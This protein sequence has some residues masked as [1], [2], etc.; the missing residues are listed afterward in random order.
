M[1]TYDAISKLLKIFKDI[2][3]HRSVI[4][5]PKY[6]PV[7]LLIII[8]G[9]AYLYDYQD[10]LTLR[11]QGPHQWRQCDCLSITSKFYLNESSFFQPE[12]YNLLKDNEGKAASDFP[13]VYYLTQV[14]I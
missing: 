6:S 8:L 2:F 14:A 13:L 7:V 1:K 4:F 12:I 11:P 9:F 10:I 3:A 5:F